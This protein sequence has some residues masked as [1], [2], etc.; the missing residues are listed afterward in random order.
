MEP[1]SFSECG[2]LM[3]QTTSGRWQGGMTLPS[4]REVKIIVS[5]EPQSPPPT[6]Q[7]HETALRRIRW[8]RS[9]EP[10]ILAAVADRMFDGWIAGW[11]DDEFDTITSKEQFTKELTVDGIILY[12]RPSLELIITAGNLFGG[13]SIT[14]EVGEAGEILTEPNIFG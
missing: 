7:W 2:L 6:E 9:H 4:G 11:R 3:W 8:V 1:I 14:F 10:T 5:P 12:E 13:H